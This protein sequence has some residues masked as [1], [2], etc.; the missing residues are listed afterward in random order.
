[1]R[2]LNTAMRRTALRLALLIAVVGATAATPASAAVTPGW[3]M[4][5]Q[6]PTRTGVDPGGSPFV[7]LTQQWSTGALDGAVFAEPVVVGDEVIV[8]T[9]N[10]SV[11]AYD[12]A[13]RPLWMKHLATPAPLSLIAS[14]GAPCGDIDPLGITSTPVVDMARNE[15]F[16]AAE[17]KLGQAVAHRLYGLDLTTGAV[18][19]AGAHLDPPGM[20]VAA[21]QQRAALGLASGRVYVAFGGLFGDCG[22]Y[23]GWV[24][25]VKESGLGL[26]AYQVPTQREGGIWGE[27]GPAI[28]S[29]GNV[30]VSVG[31]GSQVNPQGTYDG[32]DSVVKLSSTLHQ[33]SLFAPTSWAVDNLNDADLGS[34]GPALLKNG[35]VFQVG[36]QQTGF[37]LAAANLGGIGGQI[38]G[39]TVCTAFGGT[40]YHNPY[41][42]VPCTDGIRAVKLLPGPD[43]NVTWHT[44][45]PA[46]GPPIVAFGL[47]WSIDTSGGVLYGLDANTGAIVAHVS[48][49]GVQSF[50]T[51]TAVG[52]RLF[53]PIASGVTAFKNG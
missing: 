43:F 16:V 24:V 21:H 14:L 30:Y 36:K 32:S 48:I 44:P 50:V 2:C 51:P 20:V 4:Y 5:H 38:V 31:N 18:K 45:A 9:E 35:L 46:N 7:K 37:L 39:H 12:L 19:L 40:A 26:V 47:V 10:D 23:H 53:V 11:W 3:T 15:V 1:M 49:G 6:N 8:A 13:G 28:D 33:L 17:V 52:N 25:S 41:V 27:S 22:Q 42:Y 29:T 34:V